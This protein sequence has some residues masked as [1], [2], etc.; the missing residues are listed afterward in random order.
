MFEFSKFRL[1]QY[2]NDGL[3][4]I[5]FN[6]PTKIQDLVIPRAIMNESLVVESATGSGKTH[7]FLIVYHSNP[8][9]YLK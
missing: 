9:Y 8:K 2:I 7:S 5:G 6:S 1:K 4:H 3:K